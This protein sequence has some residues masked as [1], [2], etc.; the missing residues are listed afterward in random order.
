MTGKGAPRIRSRPMVMARG[1]RDRQGWWARWRC[2]GVLAFLV[3]VWGA[4]GSACGAV[5]EAYA[6][7]SA[8]TEKVFKVTVIEQDEEVERRVLCTRVLPATR[9][10]GQEVIPVKVSVVITPKSTATWN[11]TEYLA[12]SSDRLEVVGAKY[13]HDA[14]VHIKSDVRLRAPLD[15]GATW[16]SGHYE[17]VVE[18]QNDQVIVS[19]G[20]FGNCLRIKTTRRIDGELVYDETAWHAPGL[21]QIKSLAS[22]PLEHSQFITQLM[23]VKNLNRKNP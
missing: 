10:G 1:S 14:E 21:G 22:Y 15:E 13:P 12:L 16:K 11:F 4:P 2:G 23:E 20:T 9:I 3:L 6:G 8:G 7:L 18:G 17:K 19:A 5:V